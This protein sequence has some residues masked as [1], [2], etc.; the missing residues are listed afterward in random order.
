MADNILK[1]KKF[2]FPFHTIGKIERLY[3]IKFFPVVKNFFN[4]F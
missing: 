4:L 3:F 1:E 2:S